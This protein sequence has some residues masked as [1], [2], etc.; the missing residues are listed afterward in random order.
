MLD[1]D[2][3][4]RLAATNFQQAEAHLTDCEIQLRKLRAKLEKCAG[5]VQQAPPEEHLWQQVDGIIQGEPVEAEVDE[6]T[7]KAAA[8]L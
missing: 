1:T 6:E 2:G 7:E 5:V 4:F 3:L 8:L